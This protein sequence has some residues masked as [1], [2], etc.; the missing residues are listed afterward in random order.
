[1]S[2]GKTPN[3]EYDANFLPEIKE[4]VLIIDRNGYDLWVGIIVQND[5]GKFT[6][7][8]P[9][10][11]EE[12]EIIDLD[13]N[14]ILKWTR[15]NSRIFNQQE[16]RRNQQQQDGEEEEDQDDDESDESGSNEPEYKPPSASPFEKEGK[17]K[18]GSKSKKSKKNKE[19]YRPRPEGAR[20]NPRRGSSKE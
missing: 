9:D 18:K 19:V 5:N 6:V 4:K 13:A 8:Y 2:E 20:T 12:D 7:H 14:R 17:K 3:F 15:A 10:Y 11:Q 1:M 16:M